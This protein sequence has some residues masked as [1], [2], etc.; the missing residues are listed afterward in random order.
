MKIP[1]S[2][3]SADGLVLGFFA[4][5]GCGGLVDASGELVSHASGGTTATGGTSATGWAYT[6]GTSSL[7]GSTSTGDSR[8]CTSDSDCTQCLYIT[9]PSN[10]N[11]CTDALGCCG[12]QVMNATTCAGNQ[13]AW[14]ANCSGYGYTIQGCPCISCGTCTLSCRNGECGFY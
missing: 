3:L 6:G 7:G 8:A 1:L 10:S 9:A 13:A 5:A 14:E 11:Q 4:L 2:A 12:G